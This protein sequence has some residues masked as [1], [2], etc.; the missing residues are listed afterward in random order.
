M[1]AYS[2]IVV[3]SRG[4]FFR[5]GDFDGQVAPKNPLGIPAL[6]QCFIHH[7]DGTRDFSFYNFA[8][9]NA[10]GDRGV[11]IQEIVL[12]ENTE[13]CQ[14]GLLDHDFISNRFGDN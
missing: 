9:P 4:L 3:R 2:S 12:E 5:F 6:A 7:R 1:N 10:N 8:I 14:F 11:H 13:L